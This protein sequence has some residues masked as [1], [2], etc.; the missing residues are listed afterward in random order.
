LSFAFPVPHQ[1]VKPQE[2][3]LTLPD[4]TEPLATRLV[5]HVG[6]D[7][8]KINLPREMCVSDCH[9]YI[10]LHICGI[11]GACRGFAVK[12]LPSNCFFQ[13]NDT[14]QHV[15][16]E[17]G[18]P[19][20]TYDKLEDKMKI[21]RDSYK[22]AKQ[23]Q[24]SSAPDYFFNYFDLGM[25]ILFDGET[26]TVKKVVVHTNIPGQS[27]FNQYRRCHYH[28]LRLKTN[29][30][31]FAKHEKQ[32]FDD[33]SR[34]F[35]LEPGML[36]SDTDHYDTSRESSP[37]PLTQPKRNSLICVLDG[38]DDVA[39]KAPTLNTDGKV[40]SKKKKKKKKKKTSNNAENISSVLKDDQIKSA[41]GA[42]NQSSSSMY[43]ND[44]LNTSNNTGQACESHAP[45]F[46]IRVSTPWSEIEATLGKATGPMIRAP[47]DAGK[48]DT[49]GRMCAPSPFSA[50]KIYAYNGMIYEVLQN[51]FVSNVTFFCTSA[52]K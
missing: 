46:V 2:I 45:H 4:G 36:T 37:V 30:N 52:V 25:D 34:Q 18:I 8:R 51:E 42:A 22:S 50:T 5:I 38:S 33:L 10:S 48:Y 32:S 12:M 31:S 11:N 7:L 47:S 16:S 6:P 3:P 28:I 19:S 13:Y 9:A 27:E 21:H 1:A 49:S 35:Q 14:V 24:N 15:L 23:K 26:H 17:L 40:P 20:S 41:N 39:A 43:T 44:L 29:K